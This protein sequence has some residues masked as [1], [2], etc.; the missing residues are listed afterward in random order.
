MSNDIARDRMLELLADRAIFGLNEAETAEL[1]E[2]ETR[3]PE[4]ASDKSFERAAAVY[5]VSTVGT[6]EQM[7][8]SLRTRLEAAAAEMF[9]E[10]AEVPAMEIP[11]PVTAVGFDKPG[12]SFSQWLGW[13][14]A[15]VAA[16]LLAFNIWTSRMPGEAEVAQAPTPEPTTQAEP[17]VG[18]RLRQLVASTDDLVRTKWSSPTEEGSVSGEVVWSDDKQSGF[19]TFKGLDANDVSKETYQLWIFD[20]S[21]DEATPID[22]GVFDISS[23]GEVTVPIDAK[24]AVKNPKMFAVTVEKPGGVVVSKR[25]KI[26][27][28]AKV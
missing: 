14:V 18:E 25:E 2:L 22:G 9:A 10:E 4:L 6:I 8:A 11:A 13:G 21:Q 28:I 19:M 27:A 16:V 12:F 20:E 1:R 24:L 7:P 17:S 5:S 26:V 15:A 23:E 3:F